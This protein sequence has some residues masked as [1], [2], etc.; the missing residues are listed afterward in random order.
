MGMVGTMV[1][2]NV[3]MDSSSPSY[4]SRVQSHESMSSLENQ[5]EE[6]DD[7]ENDDD[8][9]DNEN[10]NDEG[11]RVTT[12]DEDDVALWGKKKPKNFYQYWNSKS[13]SSSRSRHQQ[14]QCQEGGSSSLSYRFVMSRFIRIAS[15][16]S[17]F[18]LLIWRDDVVLQPI[19]NNTTTSGGGSTPAEQ[20]RG[21]GASPRR[22]VAGAGRQT[23]DLGT[24]DNNFEHKGRIVKDFQ[25]QMDLTFQSS[26][27]SSDLTQKVVG[28]TPPVDEQ[29]LVALGRNTSKKRPPRLAQ[30]NTLTTQYQVR[31][32]MP[33]P[34]LT[35]RTTTVDEE[36][37]I[38][39]SSHEKF[40]LTEE[41]IAKSSIHTRPHR[42]SFAMSF[43][44]QVI[45]ILA[46]LCFSLAVLDMAWCVFQKSCPLRSCWWYTSC[47][48]RGYPVWQSFRGRGSNSGGIGSG[49]GSSRVVVNQFGS[50]GGRGRGFWGPIQEWV[51]GPLVSFTLLLSPQGYSYNADR[52]RDRSR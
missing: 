6:D 42:M 9:H 32:G 13:Y 10:E 1:V 52:S 38:S 20:T 47:C 12:E 27:S 7:D 51:W 43:F 36:S 28:S 11:V 21:D 25:G 39:S 18:V 49:N 33:Q 35:T 23:G 50:G 30:A 17:L 3:S 15:I 31:N 29:V 16:L 19:N 14:Q 4:Y 46:K 34:V 41:D 2:L 26:S 5:E 22:I 37:S 44:I 45:I 24:R 48:G 8:D 40:I